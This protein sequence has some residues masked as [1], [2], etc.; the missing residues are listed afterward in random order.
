MKFSVVQNI[1]KVGNLFRVIV[2]HVLSILFYRIRWEPG[3][4][5]TTIDRH[6]WNRIPFTPLMW[7]ETFLGYGLRKRWIARH[8]NHK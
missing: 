5:V 1:L 8:L 2:P 3:D 6:R 4:H 7:R